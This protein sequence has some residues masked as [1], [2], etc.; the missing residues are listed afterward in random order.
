M[1]TPALEK[2]ALI[3]TLK[4]TPVNQISLLRMSATSTGEFP[5]WLI[6]TF[7][8]EFQK[9]FPRLLAQAEK[10]IKAT[11]VSE[12]DLAIQRAEAELIKLREALKELKKNGTK[13]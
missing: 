13:E 2:L 4:G 9:D 1:T 3:E 11:G 12:L 7:L 6:N 10:A 5:A 8:P